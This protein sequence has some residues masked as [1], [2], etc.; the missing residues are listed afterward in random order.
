MLD[1]KKTIIAL[2]QRGHGKTTLTADPDRLK[3]WSQYALDA[4]VFLRKMNITSAIFM[5]HS[6]GSIVASEVIK[7]GDFKVS[8]LIMLDPVLFYDP[9]TAIFSEIKN[10]FILLRS[11]DKV[12]APPKDEISLKVLNKLLCIT[13]EEVCLKP[14]L[15]NRLKNYL[16]GGLIEEGSGLKLS[17][18]PIWESKTFETVSFNTYRT[19]NYLNLPTLILRAEHFSTFSSKGMKYLSKKNNFEVIE[20]EGSHFFPIENSKKTSNLIQKFISQNN[21]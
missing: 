1:S 8:H 2:D 10:K 17:C 19:L 7:R 12:V 16:S 11:N 13:K 18:S 4:D 9:Y 5:G 20:V 21:D 3:S 14:G 15:W 6:M